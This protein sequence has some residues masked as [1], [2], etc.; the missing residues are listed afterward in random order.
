MYMRRIAYLTSLLEVTIFN[1]IE[2]EAA[3]VKSIDVE[4]S[5]VACGPY[6]LAV[7]MNNRA[8][9]YFVSEDSK[10]EL[11]KQLGIK[12]NYVNNNKLWRV[13]M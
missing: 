6:H 10:S 9:F 3:I 12:K 1:S 5:F 7:G 2:G 11:E 8:W 13:A 4:P